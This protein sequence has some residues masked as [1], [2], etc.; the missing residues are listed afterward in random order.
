VK[1]VASG[2]G[3]GIVPWSGT[4][5]VP[6]GT[7]LQELIDG[8]P[9]SVA[10]VADGIRAVPFAITRQLVGDA[11]F[12]A[13]GYQYCGSIL[14]PAD[15]AQLGGG[16]ALFA[17]ATR[18]VQA[19]VDAFQ[20]VGV[21]GI[22][23]IARDGIPVPIELNP[24]WSASMELAERAYG[25]SVFA[26]HVAGCTGREPPSFS[27][28]AVLGE[29]GAVGKAIVYA[30]RTVTLSDTRRWLDDP[31]LRDVPPPGARIPRGKPICT[32]FARGADAAA[33]YAEL[34]RRAAALYTE[35]GKRANA[36]RS[37]RAIA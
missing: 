11:A 30:R 10:F 13:S 4:R 7:V 8:V 36:P 18:L 1:R 3:R 14:A 28:A 22:D 33:C 23:F 2:G 15:D 27:L 26:A 25:L 6:R 31:D 16:A 17:G 35:I 12:G 29:R 9:A 32:L 21:N 5:R 19:A 37:P 24:R 20:L 34:V